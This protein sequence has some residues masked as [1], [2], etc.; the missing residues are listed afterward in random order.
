MIAISIYQKILGVNC[1]KGDRKVSNGIHFQLR[2]NDKKD[3][4]GDFVEFWEFLCLPV[5]IRKRWFPKENLFAAFYARDSL[6]YS[7][8]FQKI[9]ILLCFI[10]LNWCWVICLLRVE[11]TRETNESELFSVK[12]KVPLWSNFRCPFFYIFVHGRSSLDILPKFNTSFTSMPNEELEQG[13][14]MAALNSRK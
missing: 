10:K 3:K 1:R 11:R 14:L 2:S 7:N 9:S 12:F 8:Y 6:L 13:K 4:L 5:S